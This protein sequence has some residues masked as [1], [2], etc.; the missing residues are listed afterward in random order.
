MKLF[1]YF[2][3]GIV[4][5]FLQLGNLKADTYPDV[6][7]DNS[8]VSGVYAK[9]EVRYEGDSWVENLN[10]HLLVSDTLFFT[11]GNALSL[12]YRSGKSGDWQAELKYSRQKLHYQLNN[13]DFLVLKIFIKSEHT[14]KKQLPKIAI[15]QRDNES[16]F[17]DLASFIEDFGYSTWLNVKIPL[18]RFKN[19]NMEEAVRAVRFYQNESDGKTHHIFI[20]QVEFLSKNYSTATLSSAAI[21]SSAVAYDKQIHLQ[22]QLPLTPSIRYIKIYRSEDNTNFQPVD[23]RPITMQGCFTYVPEVNRTYYYKI[24]WVDYNYVESPFSEVKEVRTQPLDKDK[25][26]DLVQ[27]AHV[28]YFLENYDINS[29][30]YLPSRGK[31]KA[32]VSVK[33]SGHAVL[34]LIV[35]AERGLI[36]RQ[37]VLNRI[38]RMVFFLLKGQHRYGFFPAYFD[39]RAGVPDY[40][41]GEASYDVV[42]T[43]T[44]IE[45]LL[46][47]RQY[48]S[49]ENEAEADL[50]NRIT[51]L[52]QQVQWNK[53][54][55]L[56]TDDVLVEHISGID[57][58]SNASLQYATLG[59]VNETMNAYILG[60]AAPKYKLPLSAYE[61]G[62]KKIQFDSLHLDQ[63]VDSIYSD[64]LSWSLNP[65]DFVHKQLQKS[66]EDTLISVLPLRGSILKDTIVYGEKLPFGWDNHSLL[67]LYKPFFTINPVNLRDKEV[68]YLSAIKNYILARKRKDNEVGVGSTHSDIWGF[69]QFRDSIGGFRVNPA[70]APAAMFALR[71]VGERSIDA[72]YQHYGNRLFTE[73][74]FRAWLDLRNDD[75]SDEYFAGNQAAV[76]IL[77]ENARSGLIWRLY[78][79]I[80]EI[81][82]VM[83]QLFDEHEKKN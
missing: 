50:R 34:S 16:E 15:R 56:N 21:L 22:W 80:P 69:Y 62:I 72:L 60:M 43:T 8:L 52:W 4:Y 13:T 5:L 66:Q 58:A 7:F 68:D 74:G 65:Y 71:D 28:N 67:E 37:V 40:R 39:G 45:A 47:A 76:S 3:L 64:T 18:S 77:L 2:L 61:N 51:Q 26:L 19:L 29:G 54:I 79:E 12:Q 27:A 33:E 25:L 63:P 38:S 17:L 36:Q 70:I 59:G 9:S 75:V 53:A 35:G 42:A 11:P 23:I 78:S 6:I 41:G 81:K 73:Y 31:D 82:E 57:T 55:M 10:R 49:N 1:L 32:V 20:D 30:M 14:S 46:V 83:E 44:M 24:A 48:F